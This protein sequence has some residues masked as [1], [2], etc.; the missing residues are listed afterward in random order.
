MRNGS[1]E[2]L[3]RAKVAF[4]RYLGEL[5]PQSNPR[6]RDDPA[7]IHIGSRAYCRRT[8]YHG[9]PHVKKIFTTATPGRQAFAAEKLAQSQ[10]ANQP[11]MLPWTRSGLNWFASPLLPSDCRLDHLAPKL[12]QPGRLLIAGQILSIILDMHRAGFAHRDLHAGN[13]FVVDGKLIVTDFETLTRYPGPLPPP[14]RESYDITGR[15]LES[16]YMTG[17]KCFTSPHRL[18]VT[19]VLGVSLDEALG[20]LRVLLK[21]DLRTASLT[22]YKGNKNRHNCRAQRIY[23]SFDLLQLS[24]SADEA[25]RNSQRRFE[26]FGLTPGMAVGKRILDLGSNVGGMLFEAQR[27]QPSQSLGVE[28]D[29]DKVAIANRVATYCE[30]P[31]LR[32]MQGDIDRL[33]VAKCGGPYDIVL[34]LAIEAHV[35]K[36]KRLYRLL[37]EVTSQVLYFEGNSGC[38]V[39]ESVAL[40]ERA[41]FRT[42][43][44][45][46]NSDD[47]CLPQNHNRPILR[48]YK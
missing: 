11:W 16:P 9:V 10:F 22:F 48:A 31:S 3:K 42:V 37:G 45:L 26:L 34:C 18:S 43:E 1:N 46:G 47:D 15:G 21:D 14:F 33:T 13:L 4:H 30:A 35:K 25:Q 40:L 41:G 7:V 44:H 39:A 20:E 36:P 8:T 5:P 6:L 2:W 32:F 17:N 27:F 12:D 23:C 38:N 19:S 29:A 28:Y 24:V